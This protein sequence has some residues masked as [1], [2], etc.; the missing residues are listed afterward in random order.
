[1]I[2]GGPHNSKLA[3]SVTVLF[4]LVAV[5]PLGVCA[6]VLVGK[7]NQQIKQTQVEQFDATLRSYGNTLIGRLVSADDVLQS[8]V[9]QAAPTGDT[10]R[11]ELRKAEWLSELR[12]VGAREHPPAMFPAKSKSALAAGKSILTWRFDGNDS[13]IYLVHRLT[14]GDLLFAKINSAWLW[15]DLDSFAGKSTLTV[16]DDQGR[17]LAIAGD[18]L[19]KATS[20][21]VRTWEVFLSG[22]FAAPSWRVSM[23]SPMPGLFSNQDGRTYLY[24]LGF[25]VL[26]ILLISWVSMAA[27]RHQLRPLRILSLATRRVAKREF[28]AF[29][30]LHWDNEFGELAHSFQAMA[31]KLKLQFGVLDS[32]SDVD[33]QLMNS[34]RLESILDAL[35]PQLTDL[36]GCETVSL[37]LMNDSFKG[38]LAFDFIRGQKTSVTPRPIEPGEALR[39]AQAGRAEDET[40]TEQ[41]HLLRPILPNCSRPIVDIQVENLGDESAGAILCLGYAEP[42]EQRV[43]ASV[44]IRDFAD[45]LALVL[46]NLQHAESLRKQAH[47]DSL[48]G[49]ESRSKFTTNA[50]VALSECLNSESSGYLLY[51]DLDQFK[52]VNDTAG[53]ATGDK[54]LKVVANRILACAGDHHV[55]RLGGDEFALLSAHGAQSQQAENLSRRVITALEQDIEIDGR[56]HRISA[57]VGIALFPA[58]GRTVEELLKA[59]DIAMY[60]AKT[61]G[62]GRTQLFHHGMQQR[63]NE[64]VQLE[65]ELI[66]AWE[67]SEF[68]LHYQPIVDEANGTLAAEA[69]IRWIN[70]RSLTPVAPSTFVPLAEANGLIVRLGKWIMRNAC[71]QF[72]AWRRLGIDLKYIS[73]NVSVRQLQEPAYCDELTAILTEFGVRADQLQIEVTESVLAHEDEMRPSLEKIASLGVRLALDDFGTGYSSLSY[74][75]SFPIRNVKIDR[76][77]IMGLPYDTVSCQLTSS[78]VALCLALGK[79]VTA[80]GVETDAQLTYLRGL[81]CPCAQG[82]LLGRP[83][84]ADDFPGFAQRL[85][86]QAALDAA[87]TPM[88]VC[89]A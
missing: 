33:R 41:L 11:S 50:Q 74:L 69:L 70:P 77:F 22:R 25:L 34:P 78:I 24:L 83:M 23:M 46:A 7:F 52:Y 81:G 12:L 73:V 14:N 62:R 2:A 76:S 58:H 9:N 86:G 44:S 17:T 79:E 54:L 51:I 45:R 49:L 28:D 31:Q 61:A 89:G 27:I 57:S 59:G 4:L 37:L 13:S 60:C 43:E 84:E 1:M 38:A 56:R 67:N 65:K 53:H 63:L 20:Q 21:N 48:T 82:Y 47:F 42:P 30:G 18:S 26:S 75:R 16:L 39:R 80:E 88:T 29:A 3:H 36:L 35:L 87:P 19:D 68:V 10:I 15:N 5:I 55:S 64:Q 32:L 6:A 40:S 8:L 85:R 71:R 72:A 66:E